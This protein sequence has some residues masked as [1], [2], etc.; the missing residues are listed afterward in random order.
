MTSSSTLFLRRFKHRDD[1]HNPLCEE[2]RIVINAGIIGLGKMGLSHYAILNTHP[3]VRLAAVCDSTPFM[4][5]VLQRHAKGQVFYADYRKMID[6]QNLDCVVVSTPTVTHG[7]IVRYAL[8]RNIHVFVEKPFC[9]TLSEGEELTRLAQGRGL[10]NQ[11]GYHN[12]FIGAFNEVKR[13]ADLGAIGEVY[14]F[15]AEAYGPVVMH[16]PKASWRFRRSEG[17]GCLYDYASHIINLVNYL[18]GMPSGASGTVL[19]RVFSRDVEDAVYAT[20]AYANGRSG[21]LS[22]NWSDDT[23]RKMTNRLSLW[24]NRGKIYADR[25]ECRIYLREENESLALTQGW[26]IRYTTDL[27]PP[28]DFYLRGEEYTAQLWY[29]VRCIAE[30]RPENVNSFE[31]ALQTDEVID[32]LRQDGERGAG[33]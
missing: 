24:G 1:L 25:Q 11:V 5:T 23:Y 3:E 16:P 17:G 26:N 13:L 19:Q 22:V 31:S 6:E 18:F 20:L 32:L 30:K 14:H 15:H 4:L 21:Q 2:M 9:L 7:A 28:V 12:R 8:E 10:V 33:H 29:F 27:T